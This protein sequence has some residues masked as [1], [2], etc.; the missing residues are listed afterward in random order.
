MVL[1]DVV[2]ASME[3]SGTDHEELGL[4]FGP[5]EVDWQETCTRSNPVP[6]CLHVQR[7]FGFP[8]FFDQLG[9]PQDRKKL[10]VTDANHFALSYENTLVVRESLDW[11]DRW[12]GEVR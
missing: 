5:I 3:H 4:M 6:P 2:I 1:D 11:L 8:P 12:L 7:A 10:I 9:V